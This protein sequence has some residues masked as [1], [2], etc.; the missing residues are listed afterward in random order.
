[1][2]E[3]EKYD[4]KNKLAFGV[5]NIGDM[6]AYQSFTLLIFVFYFAI[7][8]KDAILIT[9]GFIIWSLWNAFNDPLLGWLSD[10]TNKS[11]GRRKF[12]TIIAL[13]PASIV[14]VLL[15]TPPLM[16]GVADVWI[17]WIYFLIIICF[18][19]F[20]Y[21]MFSL[22][23]TSAFPEMYIEQ[24]DRN[25]ASLIRRILTIVGLIIAFLL[26]VIIIGDTE[27]LGS[28]WNGNYL[29]AGII[30]GVLVAVCLVV[31]IKWGL[32]ERK[33]FSKDPVKNPGFFESLKI[34]LKN[35]NFQVLVGGN[36]CNWY[37]Y[38]LIPT[39]I[40]LFG[41][42]VLGFAEDI[43]SSILLL[44]AFLAAAA[45]MPMWK[46]YGDKHGN[47]KAL[48]V[49]F[50][51]WG[52]GF[53]PFLFLPPHQISYFISIPIM[54]FIGLGIS[55]SILL[56]DLLI[57]DVIDD[58]EVKTGIR[59]EGAFYGVNALVVRLATVLV[60][61]SIMVIFAGN[62]WGAYTARPGTDVIMGLK[63]LMSVFPAGAA[64]I[65]AYFFHKFPLKG[66]KLAEVKEKLEKIHKDKSE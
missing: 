65:G 31:V 62:G 40:L 64:F 53:I 5:G 2:A 21:T 57:S 25:Q 46:K 42:H 3:L 48:V 52:I 6:I 9:I 12:W 8:I 19:D 44:L 66:Q 32:K 59:R 34:T 56:M 22:N 29:I 26:P 24:S 50:I 41:Q 30:L 49:S 20:A 15:F 51:L 11:M 18:F 17:N 14:M 4:L 13:V 28:F 63:I 1:M 35:R 7:V 16:F 58:D 55:G 45:F 10:R 61:V 60:M 38:G 33:E 23:V 47:Q 43:Y 37:I 54:I 27:A 36:L 39:I